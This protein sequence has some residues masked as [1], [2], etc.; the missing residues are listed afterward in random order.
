MDDDIRVGIHAGHFCEL[1]SSLLCNIELG[2][3]ENLNKISFNNNFKKLINSA[4]ST[5][6]EEISRLVIPQVLRA[7]YNLR[8]KKKFAHFKKAI[9]VKID[10]KYIFN[11]VEWVIAQ[12]LILYGNYNDIEVIKFLEQISY[13][14]YKNLERFENGEIYFYEDLTLEEIIL[15]Y[16]GEEYNSG[17]ISKESLFEKLDY[18]NKNYYNKLI[19]KL[20]NGKLIHI[21]ENGILLSFKGMKRV[22]EIRKI[23]IEDSNS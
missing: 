20:R 18:G 7:V 14:V 4:K 12:L 19:E 11:S 22:R 21:N 17:R 6:K 16:L 15:F 8:N 23:L 5:S 10:L 2:I 13:E 3:T 1:V 9:P